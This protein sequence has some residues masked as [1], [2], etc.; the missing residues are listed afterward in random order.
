[1]IGDLLL[2]IGHL[3]QIRIGPVLLASG[4]L[5]WDFGITGRGD[6]RPLELAVRAHSLATCLELRREL[7]LRIACLPLERSR[8]MNGEV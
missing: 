1:V 6:D 7:I 8:H 2:E 4:P 5:P 3:E